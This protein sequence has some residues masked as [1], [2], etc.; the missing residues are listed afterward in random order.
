MRDRGSANGIRAV[1]RRGGAPVL[2]VVLI[3]AAGT[4]GRIDAAGDGVPV[5]KLRESI[6]CCPGDS[7]VLDG[8]ASVD[9]GGEVVEWLWDTNGDGIVDAATDRG[10]LHMTAPA[11]TAT[12]HITLRVRDNS[13]NVSAADSAVLHVINSRPRIVLPS[14]TTVMMGARVTFQPRVATECGRIQLYQWDFD[15]D[16]NYEHKSSENGVTSRVYYR[17]GHYIARLLVVDSNGHEAG[18]VISVTVQA[19]PKAAQ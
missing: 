14:D 3:I 17:P 15:E 2:C 16:G 13:G 11:R 6:I 1:M 5:A 19:R 9:P 8:W 10:E 18:G 12:L 4:A 7:M